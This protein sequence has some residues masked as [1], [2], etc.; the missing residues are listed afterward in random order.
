MPRAKAAAL[1]AVQLNEMDSEA[2]AILG[3]VAGAFDYDWTEALRRY[4]LA[5]ACEPVSLMAQHWCAQFILIPLRRCDEAIALIEPLLIT[6]PCALFLRKA[7][8][9]AL[10]VRGDSDRALEELGASSN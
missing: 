2:H 4:R 8:A 3:Q 9:D 7:L 1:R 6:D 5:L 10:A